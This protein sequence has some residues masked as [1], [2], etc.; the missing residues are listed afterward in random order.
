MGNLDLIVATTI[1]VILFAI[2][3]VTTLN[4]FNKMNREGYTPG[5][6]AKGNE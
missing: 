3:I 2:F 1:A 6:K 4:E 5:N